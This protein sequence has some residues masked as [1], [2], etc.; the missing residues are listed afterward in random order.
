MLR[1]AENVLLLVPEANY[2]LSPSELSERLVRLTGTIADALPLRALGIAGGDTS[3]V[4]PRR[5][6][7]KAPIS[8]AGLAQGFAERTPRISRAMAYGWFWMAGRAVVLKFGHVR[9]KS[10]ADTF[11]NRPAT[12]VPGR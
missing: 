7:S 11:A 3:S 1:E 5:L 12:K 9:V 6:G 4:I 10:I 2:G 8:K